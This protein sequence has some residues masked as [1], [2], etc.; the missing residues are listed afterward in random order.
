MRTTITTWADGFGTWHASIDERG[1]GHH[2]TAEALALTAIREELRPRE[3]PVAN[4][5][6][7]SVRL[8]NR[9]SQGKRLVTEFVEHWPGEEESCAP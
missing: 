2:E 6:A 7:M 5:D 4:L 8:V 1:V 9:T 3:G